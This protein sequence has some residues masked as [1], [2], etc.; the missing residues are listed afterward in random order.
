MPYSNG[1]PCITV[2]VPSGNVGHGYE[3][4][5]VYIDR[6]LRLLSVCNNPCNPVF[7]LRYKQKVEF[8]FDHKD[9]DLQRSIM[10]AG[11]RNYRV[12]SCHG[13]L[14]HKT[15]EQVYMKYY[16]YILAWNGH[17]PDSEKGMKSDA[18]KDFEKK[19]SD[20]CINSINNKHLLRFVSEE[21]DYILFVAQR[22]AGSLE[23]CVASFSAN[24]Q[25]FEY[26]D[27]IK[28]CF[29]DCSISSRD[30]ITEDD[31]VDSLSTAKK[32]YSGDIVLFFYRSFIAGN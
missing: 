24:D 27:R 11:N 13:R 2:G 28:S 25:D 3:T 17:N 21:Y 18:D 7:A 23:L 22:T 15:G 10:G 1:D 9:P 14:I 30:E 32:F 31:F 12:C 26:E 16:K 6:A 19:Y 4:G 8:R 29:P 5:Q 20:F